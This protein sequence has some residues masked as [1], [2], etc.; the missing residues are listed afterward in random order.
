[1]VYEGDHISVT[2]DSEE[3]IF[4]SR[5][6]STVDITKF[7]DFSLLT[8]GVYKVEI[9]KAYEIETLHI[10]VK[11]DK[12]TLVPDSQKKIYKPVI[13]TENGQVIISKIALDSNKMNVELYF[14]DELIYSE[15]VEN[16]GDILNRVYK[17]DLTNRGNYKAIIKTN[18]RKYVEKFKI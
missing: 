18:N 15:K 2:N 8:D 16:D 3:I 9:T 10:D 12:V 6:K 11:S 17:L 13:R 5:I 14:E 4:S 1:M 7:F